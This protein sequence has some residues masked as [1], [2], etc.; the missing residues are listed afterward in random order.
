MPLKGEGAL[1]GS[2]GLAGNTDEFAVFALRHLAD[3]EMLRANLLDHLAV[4]Y[5]ILGDGHAEARRFGFSLHSGLH[6]KCAHRPATLAT[7]ALVS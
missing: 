6:T 2:D 5:S 7:Q 4:S 3:E 1:S